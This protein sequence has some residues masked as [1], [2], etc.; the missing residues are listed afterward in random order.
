MRATDDD[1]TG[2]CSESKDDDQRP[3]R[4]T[5]CNTGILIL[6]NTARFQFGANV[7]IQVLFYR[8]SFLIQQ[9][10]RKECD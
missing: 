5:L 10:I 6:P 8:L 7:V 2:S 4:D 9:I 1:G 3:R